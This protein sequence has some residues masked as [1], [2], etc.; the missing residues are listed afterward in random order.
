MHSMLG[1]QE[2][3]SD[4]VSNEA[5]LG[6]CQACVVACS[7]PWRHQQLSSTNHAYLLRTRNSASTASPW[8]CQHGVQTSFD[9][10]QQAAAPWP[11]QQL[12]RQRNL[13]AIIRQSGST[14]RVPA[15]EGSTHSV[16]TQRCDGMRSRCR[17]GQWLATPS[18][19]FLQVRCRRSRCSYRPWL[20][21]PMA[22]SVSHASNSTCVT[23]I[24]RPCSI[25]Q[26]LPACCSSPVTLRCFHCEIETAAQLLPSD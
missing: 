19:R 20:V 10:Q 21:R 25:R 12:R 15:V 13:R 3:A 5:A 8:L 22:E 11:G 2:V 17:R 26:M 7:S 9:V 14:I 18:V 6:Q 16:I 24:A 1:A 4:S 23:A